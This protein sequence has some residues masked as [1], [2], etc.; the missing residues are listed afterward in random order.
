MSQPV[1]SDVCGEGWIACVN[2]TF[3]PLGRLG[4]STEPLGTSALQ[5][6]CMLWL[7]CVFE[8]FPYNHFVTAMHDFWLHANHPACPTALQALLLCV[9]KLFPLPFPSAFPPFPPMHT[10][11]YRDNFPW[12]C[13]CV[14]ACKASTAANS[15]VCGLYACCRWWPWPPGLTSA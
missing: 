5:V 10:R 13:V 9:G 12:V 2:T 1:G 4:M 6:V 3:D 14:R 15:V 11:T 8:I 7:P